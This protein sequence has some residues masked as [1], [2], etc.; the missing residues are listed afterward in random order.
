MPSLKKITIKISTTIT[1]SIITALRTPIAIDLFFTNCSNSVFASEGKDEMMLMIRI[2]DIPF[3]TPCSV[4]L[5]PAHIRNAEPAVIAAITVITFNALYSVSNP[6]EPNP[7]AMAP[8]SINASPTVTYLVIAAIFLRPSSP[9]FCIS[10]NL[11]IAIVISC[12]IMDEVMYGVMLSAKM[13]ILSNEPPVNAPR[14]PR[15]PFPS[16]PK[17]LSIIC[18]TNS[19]LIPGEAIWHPSRTI[20]SIKRVNNSFFLISFTLKALI[21]VLNTR[22]PLRC[23]LLLQSLL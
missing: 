20:T 2:M 21:N 6:C 23:R 13:D 16:E 11:G 7:I 5:S 3:P 22:S 1:A 18:L 8:D 10:S 12:I 17:R 9:S 4:I 15:P 14:I 19:W